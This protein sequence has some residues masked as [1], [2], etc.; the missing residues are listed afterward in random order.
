MAPKVSVNICCYNSEKFIK[1]ALESVL[2]QSYID[3]EVIII[4][5]GSV[6]DTKNIIESFSDPRI[7]YF[8]QENQGLSASRNRAV[9]LSKGQYIALLD[10]DDIWESNKLYLQVKILDNNKEIGVVFSDGYA[11][12]DKK[13]R[14][15]RFSKNS[16]PYR[17]RVENNLFKANWIACSTLVIRKNL[18]DDEK[19]SLTYKIIEEYD[20]LL[21]LS[22][23]T[24]F[25]YVNRP[26]VQYRVHDSNFSQD[27]E[28]L[29]REEIHCL[30]G[31]LSRLNNQT[32]RSV[33]L[34][35]I[36]RN[37]AEL[38]LLF[39]LK[40]MNLLAKKEISVSLKFSK[41]NILS[42]FLNSALLFPNNINYS[43]VW[44]FNK[45]R[46]LIRRI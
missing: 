11:I 42:S 5:D 8:Y 1:E 19:F 29:F 6:D 28:M 25:D 16:K 22:L 18:L 33:I 10:H 7:R 37:H 38:A 21:R 45:F 9:T 14:L 26:L 44:L 34:K 39:L 32:L 17:G 4:D 30:G 41:N 13:K 3:F 23:I 20:L 15:F 46:V 31:I 27:S 24:K 35:H 40:K 36:S 43:I 12:N 2:E